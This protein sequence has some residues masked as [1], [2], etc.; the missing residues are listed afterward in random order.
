MQ[1]NSSELIYDEKLVTRQVLIEKVEP[2]GVCLKSILI[3]SNLTIP[4]V[5][6]KNYIGQQFFAKE[7]NKKLY[8]IRLNKNL[9]FHFAIYVTNNKMFKNRIFDKLSF[10]RDE[11]SGRYCIND[12]AVLFHRISV[13]VN[14]S[15]CEVLQSYKPIKQ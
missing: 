3:T 6:Y 4:H 12:S 11:T 7:V 5:W 8:S 15:D 14:K 10:I 1:M 9:K 2:K 13:Y